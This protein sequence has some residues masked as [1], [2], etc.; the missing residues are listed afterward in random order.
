MAMRPKKIKTPIQPRNDTNPFLPRQAQCHN[1]RPDPDQFH[2]I[3]FMLIDPSCCLY[4]LAFRYSGLRL[5][6]GSFPLVVPRRLEESI[7]MLKLNWPSVK[8]VKGRSKIH[9]K[10]FL[11]NEKTANHGLT[12]ISTDFMP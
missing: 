5:G 4:P 12:P 8:D 7:N 9:R 10:G 6:G 11:T 1:V 2:I 3:T